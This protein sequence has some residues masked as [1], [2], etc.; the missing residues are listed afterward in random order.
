MWP[1][2]VSRHLAS[3]VSAQARV[4]RAAA[5]QSSGLASIIGLIM[6]MAKEGSPVFMAAS[7]ANFEI[8]ENL[9]YRQS[10]RENRDCEHRAVR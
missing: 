9:P 3:P 5:C 7:E 1:I 10:G 8:I 6:V 4:T 2:P